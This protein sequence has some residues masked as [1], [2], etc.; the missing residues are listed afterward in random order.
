MGDSKKERYNMDGADDGLGDS[1]SEERESERATSSASVQT[2]QDSSRSSD[3]SMSETEPTAEQD[4]PHRVRYDSPQEDRSALTI[5]VSDE[6]KQR[7][8]ELVDLAESEFDEKVYET[9]V[10]VAALRCDF[11]DDE[12][13][14]DEMR[15]IGYGYF[16]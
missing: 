2:Q 16:D 10:Q 13:F 9:D 3:E 15:G 12:A 7:L 14:L 1:S 5:Y 11:S 8:R 4:I 6:D